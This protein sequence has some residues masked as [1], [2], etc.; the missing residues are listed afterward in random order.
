MR[1]VFARLDGANT[2]TFFSYRV[3][4]T[5]ARRGPFTGNPLLAGLTAAQRDE[6]ARACDS[7]DWLPLLDAGLPR[8]YSA[9]LARC[10]AARAALGLDTDPAVLDGL[11]DGT[12]ALLTANPRG[13][14]DDSEDGTGGRYDIYTADLYLFCE[15]LATR[16]GDA[17]SIGAGYAVDLVERVV[18][19]NGAAVVWLSLI[20]I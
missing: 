12:R 1:T 5:L 9:V 16:L 2:H 15:P 19:G 18:A 20:H 3:A 11:V 6:V 8:N 10:E 13:Y 7:T 4:E 17:W 14:L